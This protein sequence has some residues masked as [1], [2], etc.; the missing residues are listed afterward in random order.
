MLC[1]NVQADCSE[2]TAITEKIERAGKE[3]SESLTPWGA[4]SDLY[5]IRDLWSQLIL[6]VKLCKEC[7]REIAEETEHGTSQEVDDAIRRLDEA[8]RSRF[9]D[10]QKDLD[11]VKDDTVDAFWKGFL[12][13]SFL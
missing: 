11:K 5:R 10:M 13:G 3:M 9:A 12:F 4:E 7:R 8:M 6:H 1:G 2:A